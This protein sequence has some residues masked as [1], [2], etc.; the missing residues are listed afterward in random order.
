M[1]L[2]VCV[3]DTECVCDADCVVTCV[4]VCCCAPGGAGPG[5]GAPHSP[6]ETLAGSRQ[7]PLQHHLLPVQGETQQASPQHSTAQQAS[8]QHSTAGRSLPCLIRVCLLW[9]IDGT[10]KVDTP[11]V[12]LGYS[13]ERSLGSEGGYDAVRS[14]SEGA[15]ITLFITI[16]P[17]LVPGETV[18]DKVRPFCLTLSVCLP[19]SWCLDMIIIF[20]LCLPLILPFIL[21][22]YR[23]IVRFLSSLF[24]SLC[25]L[26]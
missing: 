1:R 7:D 14:L 24:S 10:F 5:Q 11:A 17:Q 26:C 9:Q 18:R 21:F 3:C 16:E 19:V 8:P 23:F 12:L 4:C 22:L 15:F 2:S 25:C 20:C 13:K 6:G